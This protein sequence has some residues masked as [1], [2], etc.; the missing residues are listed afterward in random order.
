MKHIL[1][2][3]LSLMSA[4]NRFCVA[5]L[6]FVSL[7]CFSCDA[8]A[9]EGATQTATF[10]GGC[11]WCVE[12]VFQR[13]EGVE[14]VSPGF[15]G[16]RTKDPTYNQVLTGRTGHAEVV[17]IEYDPN[18]VSYQTLLQVF[19]RTHN[20]TTKN[21][22]GPDS[23]TQYRSVIF[24]HTEQQRRTASEYKRLL[25]RQRTFRAP[26]VT[27]ID[28]ADT[29]YPTDADHL[30]YFARNARKPYCV[31][32]IVPKLEKLKKE[33]GDQLKAEKTK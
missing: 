27:A 11:Y 24:Y 25:T 6:A 23:G 29:F 12:A 14:T 10:G 3:W 2:G 17:Q 7:C 18:V 19:F 31:A 28:S 13:I 30:N 1:S 21:K 5:T 33:F 22:Q 32:N 26:I 9:D 4:Q 8:S 15:M 16:G 20:P